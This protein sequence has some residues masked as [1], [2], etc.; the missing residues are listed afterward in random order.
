MSINI[1]LGKYSLKDSIVHKLNPV[2]KILSLIIIIVSIFFIDSY[3]DLIMLSSYI[4]LTI[5]YSDINIK[6]YL[7]NIYSIK[8]FLLL[9]FV[10]DLIFFTNINKIIFDLCKLIFIILYSSA[11]TYTTAMTEITYGIEKI[12]RPLNRI[13]PVN[14]IAM[15]ITL[16]L[17]Y[18]P[19]LTI[20]ADRIIK[21][22]TIRGINFNS[23]NIKEKITNVGSILIP[24]IVI[25]LKKSE[26]TAEIMD[27]RLYNYGK[28]R[29]NYILNKWRYLD[30][31]L[32]ILNIL[33]LI[34][35]IFY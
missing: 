34:I 22:Q 12:L 28:S 11:L 2:F 8:I 21:A 35:V 18:I 14:D 13:I 31:F 1:T 3:I 30:T 26:Q 20:E 15:M 17:R 19:T 33:I 29:T 7:K 27:T 5:I 25:S 6:L 24:M 4:L 23:R 9:I 10:I 32:L 16:T